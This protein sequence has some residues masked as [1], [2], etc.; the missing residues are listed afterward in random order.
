MVFVR[1]AR[2]KA[3]EYPGPWEDLRRTYVAVRADCARIV[4][5]YGLLYTEYRVLTMCRTG[6]VTPGS[7]ARDLGVTPAAATG[8]V[9]RLK[10]R[11]WVRK[12]PHPQD[13]RATLVGLTRS[14]RRL[15]AETRRI[16]VRRM[17]EFGSDLSP[18]EYDML[19]KG[20]AALAIALVDGAPRKRPRA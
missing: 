11:G 2:P 17:R 12:R 8:I 19:G 20:L 13:H 16:W 3:F 4:A 10:R 14:G 15:E 6:E 1:S 5:P 18:H 9:A 7:I